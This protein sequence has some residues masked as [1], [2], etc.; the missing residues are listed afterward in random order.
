MPKFGVG[1]GDAAPALD[2]ASVYNVVAFLRTLPVVSYQ[3][4]T[5]VCPVTGATGGSDAGDAGAGGGD[6]S[7]AA[8]E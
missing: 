1:R 8:G 5:T 3:A 2:D 7:D 6:A 4:Q